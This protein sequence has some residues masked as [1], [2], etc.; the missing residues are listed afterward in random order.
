MKHV[1]IIGGGIAG[2]SAAYYLERARKNGAGIEWALFEKSARFG[3]VIQTEHRD[4]YGLEA[5]PDSF[6]T[7]KPGAARLC[8]ELGN[9]DHLNGS[10]D[11]PRTTYLLSKRRLGATPEGRECVC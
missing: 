2:L 6:L 11:P 8:S 4:G 10:T 1:A 7:P 5:G 9:G 3:G